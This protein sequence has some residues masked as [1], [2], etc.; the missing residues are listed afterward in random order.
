[1]EGT[2]FEQCL[3]CN[4]KRGWWTLCCGELFVR[5]RTS[6][7]NGLSEHNVERLHRECGANVS[8]V[9]FSNTWLHWRL[10]EAFHAELNIKPSSIYQSFFSFL[11]VELGYGPLPTL[12]NLAAAAFISSALGAFLMKPHLS[13]S[14][15]I[16]LFG[17]SLPLFYA[18]IA[19]LRWLKIELLAIQLL[20]RPYFASDSMSTTSINSMH[21]FRCAE[22]ETV[23]SVTRGGSAETIR[24]EQVVPG[25][26]VHVQASRFASFLRY[27]YSLMRRRKAPGCL[28]TCE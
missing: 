28:L 16:G 22:S 7:K 18:S 27:S 25:D 12:F 1:M 2:Y 11:N 6:V 8:P 20:H 19:S 13:K 14:A 17:I 26:V 15:G 10:Y 24:W 9:K 21:A 3:C 5:F 4:Q 23:V